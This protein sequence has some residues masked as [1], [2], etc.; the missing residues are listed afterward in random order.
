MEFTKETSTSGCD[1]YCVDGT[2]IYFDGN[3]Y[4]ADRYCFIQVVDTGEAL[5]AALVDQD[6][7]EVFA[8]YLVAKPCSLEKAARKLFTI[9]EIL[10][11]E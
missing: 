9:C 3:Y 2:F 1:V 4:N 8:T 6:T 11:A 10:W 7:G 5:D